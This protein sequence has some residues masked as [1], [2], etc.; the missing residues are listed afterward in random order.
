M[1]LLD[2]IRIDDAVLWVYTHHDIDGE[3]SFAAPIQVPDKVRWEDRQESYVDG[4][5]GVAAMSTAVVYINQDVAIGDVM[6]QG[7]IAEAPDDAPM[8]LQVRAFTKLKNARGT[9]TLRIAYLGKQKG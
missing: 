2:K 1:P 7:L 5:T 4:A 9:K 8:N 6:W 3:S